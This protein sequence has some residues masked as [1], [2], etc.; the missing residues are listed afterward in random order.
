MFAAN[1][2]PSLRVTVLRAGTGLELPRS[3]AAVI[4]KATIVEPSTIVTLMGRDDRAKHCLAN[5]QKLG[6]RC[7]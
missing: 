7:V 5:W 3:R 2:S 1:S 6:V 4:V